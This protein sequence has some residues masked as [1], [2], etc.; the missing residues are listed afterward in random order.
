V[1]EERPQPF[2]EDLAARH[3]IELRAQ[4]EG[5]IGIRME[6]ALRSACVAAAPALIVGGDSPDLPLDRLESAFA[7]LE[8]PGVVVGPSSDGGYYLVGCRGPV[9]RM[10]DGH[11]WGGPTVLS[12]TVRVLERLGVPFRVLE[13]WDDV[14]D[15]D[16]LRRLAARINVSCENGPTDV[17]PACRRLLDTL[18]ADGVSL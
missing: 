14:D 7:A 10:F 8:S 17:L 11:A 5:D 6:R 12:S 18:R 13:L 16:G 9:P 4:G 3:G 15:L 2:L 1:A